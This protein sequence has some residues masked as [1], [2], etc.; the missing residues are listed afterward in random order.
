MDVWKETTKEKI[1]P[2]KRAIGLKW[3]FKI[4]R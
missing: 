2:N 4:K 1:P 3:V